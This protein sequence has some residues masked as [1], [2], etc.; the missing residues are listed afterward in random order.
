MK[1][2][3]LFYEKNKDGKVMISEEDLRELVNQA[4]DEGYKDGANA[5]PKLSCQEVFI[6]KFNG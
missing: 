6:P 2:T 5:I 3:V 4:Y 1:P